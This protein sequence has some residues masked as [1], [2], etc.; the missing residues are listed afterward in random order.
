MN[1]IEFKGFLNASSTASLKNIKPR[2]LLR[3]NQLVYD[4]IYLVLDLFPKFTSQLWLLIYRT[5]L[6]L[7]FSFFFMF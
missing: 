2:Y 1:T 6:I 7:Q 5:I 4:I 3:V